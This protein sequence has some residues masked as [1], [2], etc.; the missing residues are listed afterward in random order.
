MTAPRSERGELGA[1]HASAWI[2]V[3]RKPRTQGWTPGS[4]ARDVG[5]S[6]MIDQRQKLKRGMIAT[7]GGSILVIASALLRLPLNVADATLIIVAA[8]SAGYCLRTV[9]LLSRGELVIRAPTPEE[10][11]RRMRAKAL[12]MVIAVAVTAAWLIVIIRR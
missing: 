2:A 11:E 1:C 4:L 5:V 10:D 8:F 9:Q 3:H 7:T 12:F 6:A